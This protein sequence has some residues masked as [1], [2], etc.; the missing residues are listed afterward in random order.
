M[1]GRA[2]LCVEGEFYGFEGPSMPPQEALWGDR[3][4]A[5]VSLSRPLY[6][7]ISPG[8]DWGWGGYCAPLSGTLGICS[9]HEWRE[10]PVSW[11]W[12]FFSFYQCLCF[13]LAVGS[14]ARP[15]SEFH[16]LSNRDVHDDPHFSWGGRFL[17]QRTHALEAVST[18]V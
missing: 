4:M 1:Q 8:Q 10:E 11:T 18:H 7:P 17:T 16:H 14:E 6:V 12:K 2:P 13:L 3:L 5:V 15:L 9:S